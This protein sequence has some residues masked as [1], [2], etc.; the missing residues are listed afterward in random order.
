[1]DLNLASETYDVVPTRLAVQAMRDNGYKNAAYAIAELI[2]NSIQAG[3]KTVEL[4]CC[5]QFE[6][7]ASRVR[8]RLTT[9]AVLDNGKG[10]NAE[11]LRKALQ[12]GNGTRIDDRTGM[13]RF[14]M[15]LPSSSISQC[16]RV[17]V[18]SWQKGVDSAL[19]T[20]LDLGEI[21]K[22]ASQVPAAK[23]AKIPDF[24]LQVA[25]NF[26]PSGTLVVWSNLDRC[27]WKTAQAVIK[28]SEFIIGRMY[29]TFIH[30]GSVSIRM[31]AVR[32]DN[33]ADKA[34]SFAEPNDPLYL[35]T[36]SSCPEPF[37]SDPMFQKFGDR[38]EIPLEI[39]HNDQVHTVWLRFT[40]AK[41]AARESDQAGSR[42]HGR[43]A[44][45]NV[46]VSIVRA[47]RELELSQSWVN[48]D[49]TERWWG[50]EID[51]PPSLDE[52]FGV[53]NNKQTA[54][55]LADA[56]S[57]NMKVVLDGRTL[58]QAKEEMME[59]GDPLGPILDIAKR[60]TDNLNDIR[61]LQDR[62][63]KGMRGVARRRHLEPDSP[64]AL[65]TKASEK[66][67]LEG[68]ISQS[69]QERTLPEE[70]RVEAIEQLL[71]EQ[72]QTKE[73]AHELAATTVSSG[74]K[75]V[76]GQ[77]EIEGA[78]FFSVKIKCGTIL[79]TLNT[80][81]PAYKGLVEALDRETET[82]SL[83]ELR[84]RLGSAAGGLKLL[85]SAW[86]RMEDEPGAG[87]AREQLVD[88]RTDWGRMARM[89]LSAGG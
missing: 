16:R 17:E 29:R 7:L 12:F 42:P 35:M 64:E 57:L 23:S 84:E 9:I 63:Q 44:A 50:A 2:D 18:W 61:K 10:M 47:G 68:H 24:W 56:G 73:V 19:F 79:I 33:P 70:V 80:K 14:G 89:F 46:G 59:E 77:D 32:S 55:Y 4:I 20:Y 43:H 15:G 49:P 30:N 38:W 27:I 71:V 1:M 83:E 25:E 51:F 74:L 78:A 86:A 85:L 62:Q 87:E 88:I 53:S 39:G 22:G 40:H 26:G 52:V 41:E 45:N 65:A 28:N 82:A 21:E 58:S 81:H 34:V 76:F 3:A 36:P 37:K 11:D 67:R 8:K 6:Q 54:R 13:G 69:D 31:V 72:G 66:R 5:E 60:I 48:S 75:Y